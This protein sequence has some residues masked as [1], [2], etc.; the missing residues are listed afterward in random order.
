[1]RT[2]GHWVGGRR[3]EATSGRQSPVYNPATGVQTAAVE[4]GSAADLDAAVEVLRH[5]LDR[6]PHLDLR[7]TNLNG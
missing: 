5:F 6:A 4:L 7:F 2:I 3:A 1:M